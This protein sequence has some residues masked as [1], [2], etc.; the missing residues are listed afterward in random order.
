MQ[1]QIPENWQKVKFGEFTDSTDFVAN[2]SFAGLRQNV[3]YKSSEDYAIL[4]RSVDLKNNFSGD[5][6]FIDK[7]GYDYLKKSK[8]FGG[9]VIVTNVGEY[10]GEVFLCPD[11][12]RPMTL[13]PN[14]VM[15]KAKNGNNKFLYY[16]LKSRYGQHKLHSI[17][18]G[19]GQPKFNKTHLRDLDLVVPSKDYQDITSSILSKFD[20]K[21]EVNKKIAKTLEEMAQAIFKEWF[22]KGPSSKQLKTFDNIAMLIKGKKPKNIFS[23]PLEDSQE[24]LLIES[25]LGNKKQYTSEKNLTI[26]DDNEPVIVMDGSGS[27]KVFTGKKGAVGSTL[28]VVKAN[29]GKELY[30]FF[31]LFTIKKIGF[32]IRL[33][34][35]GSAVPHSDRD[36][37]EKFS[38]YIPNATVIKQ[39]NTIVFPILNKQKIIREENENLAQV[40]DLLLPKLM[41]GEIRV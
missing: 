16:F 6:V 1:N 25:F 10:T 13:G 27:G 32:Q 4:I 23:T 14:T 37:I 12:H 33:N 40:R 8:L 41:K 7:N 29:S 30:K 15:L 2:G 38:I 22:I 36:F 35:T 11:L 28:A 21:I 3:K 39:F 24:Y 26:C 34:L 18:S 19:S 20:D 17:I 9:E 5:K 31:I